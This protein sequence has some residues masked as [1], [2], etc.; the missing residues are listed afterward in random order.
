MAAFLKEQFDT[1]KAR[2]GDKALKDIKLFDTTKVK[3]DAAHNKYIKPIVEER[4]QL[5]YLSIL[6][7]M[8][9]G[10]DQQTYDQQFRIN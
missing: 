4:F 10:G 9:L 6:K 2:G 7:L 3:T 8:N 5:K 1:A